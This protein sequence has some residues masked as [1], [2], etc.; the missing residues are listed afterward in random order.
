[1]IKEEI[2]LEETES[3][4]KHHRKRQIKHPKFSDIQN[5]DEN[6]LD[7]KLKEHK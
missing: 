1:M 2:E 4:Q 5:D 3:E 7:K 6:F